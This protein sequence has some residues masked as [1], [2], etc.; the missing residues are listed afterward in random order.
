MLKHRS[1]SFKYFHFNEIRPGICE[2]V[3]DAISGFS[4]GGL[5][6]IPVTEKLY[7]NKIAYEIIQKALKK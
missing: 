1:K 4:A 2:L 7:G 6:S 3:K 5:K